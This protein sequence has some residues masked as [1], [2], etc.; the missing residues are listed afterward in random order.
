MPR[1]A[2]AGPD[3]GEAIL[4]ALPGV[5]PRALGTVAVSPRRAGAVPAGARCRRLMPWISGTCTSLPGVAQEAEPARAGIGTADHAHRE[6]VRLRFDQG[7]GID[8]AAL[9]RRVQPDLQL[10]T[11]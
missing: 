2:G 4:D 5:R 1:T 10:G 3:G 9:D 11:R 8:Q 7:R 6:V